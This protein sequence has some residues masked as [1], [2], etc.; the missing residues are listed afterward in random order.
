[1]AKKKETTK[2]SSTKK[3]ST[4]IKLT[5]HPIGFTA[6]SI[7][8]PLRKKNEKGINVPLIDGIPMDL[9]VKQG[10]VIT[11]T[12]KQF[13]ALQAE[14]VVE[15]D[16]EYKSRQDFLSGM[17]DQYPQTFSDLEIA[18]RKGQLIGAHEK[19]RMIYNDKLIRCD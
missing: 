13:E 1:M 10:E 17:K 15:S 7:N 3:T 14:N 19:Q 18:E 2:K 4:K 11:V 8:F 5:Y 12:K 9:E 6:P 16:E